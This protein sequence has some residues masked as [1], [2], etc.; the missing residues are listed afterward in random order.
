M[1]NYLTLTL[2]WLFLLSSFLFEDSKISLGLKGVALGV[3]IV[4]MINL[5]SEDF[6][7]KN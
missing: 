2:G 6:P 4:H 5:V 1:K 3:F 7:Q